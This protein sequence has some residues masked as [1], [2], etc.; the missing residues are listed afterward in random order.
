MQKIIISILF[1]AS[2]VEISALGTRKIIRFV[3]TSPYYY[4]ILEIYGIVD[5]NISVRKG[6]TSGSDTV[7]CTLVIKNFDH[8]S[9]RVI[10]KFGINIL[11][12]RD[13]IKYSKIFSDTLTIY[14]NRDTIYR[15]IEFNLTKE[16][17]TRLK[18]KFLPEGDY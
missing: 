6:S 9:M 15:Q 4:N 8:D 17:H 14:K 18:E 3:V 13:S 11:S 2:V 1:L 10:P 16:E 12:Y 5:S 7:Y